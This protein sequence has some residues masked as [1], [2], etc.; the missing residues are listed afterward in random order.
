MGGLLLEVVAEQLSASNYG[1]AL[2]DHCL[3][4]SAPDVP[5]PLS[6]WRDTVMTIIVHSILHD[7]ITL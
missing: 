4:L 2:D 7:I 3:L 1:Q 6:I 5:D